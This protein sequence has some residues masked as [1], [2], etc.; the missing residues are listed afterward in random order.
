MEIKIGKFRTKG[1][2]Y[3]IGSLI[4]NINP[5]AAMLVIF[6]WILFFPKSRVITP[7]ASPVPHPPKNKYA[8]NVGKL[9]MAPSAAS[10]TAPRSLKIVKLFCWIC[11]R[12]GKNAPWVM[13]APCRPKNHIRDSVKI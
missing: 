3:K 4:L 9:K 12:M 13:A 11:R 8:S 2:P 6:R 10:P 5:G 7:K 1:I